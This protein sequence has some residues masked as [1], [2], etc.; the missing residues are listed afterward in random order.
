VVPSCGC[1]EVLVECFE[2]RGFGFGWQ[3]KWEKGCGIGRGRGMGQTNGLEH[4]S[5]FGEA[6]SVKAFG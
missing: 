4:K 2:M 6:I 3:S 1:G 5:F